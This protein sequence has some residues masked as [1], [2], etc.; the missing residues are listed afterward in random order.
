MRIAV[1]LATLFT[2]FPVLVNLA[3]DK[4]WLTDP[5][6][7]A[8]LTARFSRVAVDGLY[9]R[10][11]LPS[12]SESY[13]EPRRGGANGYLAGMCAV[14]QAAQA[15]ELLLWLPN[16]GLTGWAMCAVG[17]SG[18]G[19]GT[20][21]GQRVWLTPGGGP[22]GL[23][24]YCEE[25]LL[26]TVR[27]DMHARLARLHGYVRCRC[28]HCT[29]L[30]AGRGWDYELAGRHYLGVVRR[31]MTDLAARPG[32]SRRLFARAVVDDCV[33]EQQRLELL[34]P[35]VLSGNRAQHLPLWQTFL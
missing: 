3:L 12:Y 20:S 25:S 34:M 9:L 23:G 16:S 1:H 19:T 18:A 26:H 24:R 22:Q 5:A 17:A 31:A 29:A 8:R 35:A 21:W 13:T 32:P 15:N 27:E 28:A 33:A 10:A 14:S 4:K 11:Q 30:F 2:D 6:W 7:T